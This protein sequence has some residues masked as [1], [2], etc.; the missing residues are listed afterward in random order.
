M[1][2]PILPLGLLFAYLLSGCDSKKGGKNFEV[3]SKND[4]EFELYKKLK[5][6]GV[7]P[8]EM[9]Q[10]TEKHPELNP[11]QSYL[12]LGYK[13]DSFPRLPLVHERSEAKDGKIGADELVAVARDRFSQDRDNKKFKDIVEITLPR[14]GAT[15]FDIS[16]RNRNSNVAREGLDGACP[17]DP[18][19]HRISALDPKSAAALR[20]EGFCAPDPNQALSVY[21]KMQRL[22]PLDPSAHLGEGEALYLLGKTEESLKALGKSLI[23]DERQA[24][25]HYLA[26]LVQFNMKAPDAMLRALQESVKADEKFLRGWLYLGLALEAKGDS[27]G[28]QEAI[29]QALALQTRP[30]EIPNVYFDFLVRQHLVVDENT[31]TDFPSKWPGNIPLYRERLDELSNASIER[32][33]KNPT[34]P[35][36]H[37]AMAVAQMLGGQQDREL[38][39]KSL[40]SAIEHEPQYRDAHYLLTIALAK[41]GEFEAAHDLLRAPILLTPHNKP[42][43]NAFVEFVSNAKFKK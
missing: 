16:E 6:A 28:A 14:L 41:K 7:S 21:K 23:L 1:V 5:E 4:P 32:I 24:R 18:F 43:T 36:A 9:D 25:A 37:F 31:K 30:Q 8:E 22:A 40:R 10:G 26:A 15:Y 3:P 27:A 33:Q 20:W 2:S 39:I 34:D 13:E 35:K 17:K 42:L 11:N 12:S 19:V 29:S 38:A